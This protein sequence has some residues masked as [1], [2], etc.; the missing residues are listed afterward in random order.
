MGT[1]ILH[2][3]ASWTYNISMH[4]MDT[5]HKVFPPGAFTPTQAMIAS[6]GRWS[7]LFGP[8]FYFDGFKFM[9]VVGNDAENRMTTAVSC[10]FTIVETYGVTFINRWLQQ[11]KIKGYVNARDMPIM[12]MIEFFGHPDSGNNLDPIG[13][14]KLLPLMLSEVKIKITTQGAVYACEAVPYNHASYQDSN[15]TLPANMTIDAEKLSDFYGD[16]PKSFKT[17]LNNIQKKLKADNIQYEVDEY[18]F[19][20]DPEILAATITPPDVIPS[21]QKTMDPQ[22]KEGAPQPPAGKPPAAGSASAA[23]KTI[24]AGG[25]VPNGQTTNAS[26]S[27]N[28]KPLETVVPFVTGM[29]IVDCIKI[30]ITNSTYIRDQIQNAGYNLATFK[31]PSDDPLKWYKVATEVTNLNFD[32]SRNVYAKKFKFVVIKSK[33]WQSKIPE[34]PQGNTPPV[35]REYNYIFTGKNKDIVKFDITFDTLFITSKCAVSLNPGLVRSNVER[36][37]KN[38]PGNQKNV[39]DT[40]ASTNTGKSKSAATTTAVTSSQGL[41]PQSQESFAAD[42]QAVLAG[43]LSRSILSKAGADMLTLKLTIIGDPAFIKQDDIAYMSPASGDSI[44][45]DGAEIHVLVIFKTIAD[46]N[47]NGFALPMNTSSFSGIFKIINIENEFKNGK[48]EQ[49]LEMVRIDRQETPEYNE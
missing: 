19:E 14:P 7:P 24:V 26:A 2:D 11:A 29:N 34:L 35:L 39:A 9:T 23:A 18:E 42:E 37:Q 30:S 20:I 44:A 43:V 3:Y 8:H 32:A 15:S 4:A 45:M 41:P 10:S 1:N 47:E 48:F 31:Y 28:A 16:G 25:M 5:T 17:A 40:S 21:E 36:Q 46:Y 27:A 38:N 13:T 6:G 12:I 33:V 22:P 49:V